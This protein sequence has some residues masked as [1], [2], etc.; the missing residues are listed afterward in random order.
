MCPLA[1]PGLFSYMATQEKRNRIRDARRVFERN[2]RASAEVCAQAADVNLLDLSVND[3]DF[4]YDYEPKQFS[5][6]AFGRLME[7]LTGS[8]IARRECRQL[9]RKLEEEDNR[10]RNQIARQQLQGAA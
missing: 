5:D 6:Q 3:R 8:S 7:T 9:E 10:R 4:V 1:R 2:R